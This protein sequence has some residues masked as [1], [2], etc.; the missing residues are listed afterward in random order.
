L[1]TLSKDELGGLWVIFSFSTEAGAEPSRGKG[2]GGNSGGD[3]SQAAGA[4]YGDLYVLERDGAGIPVNREITYTDPTTGLSVT[5]SCVQPISKPSCT[6]GTTTLSDCSLLPLNAEKADFDPELEDP[7]GVQAEYAVCLQEITFGRES[8][9]RASASVIDMSYGEAIKR[10]NS[11]AANQCSCDYET[12]YCDDE[13]GVDTRAIKRNPAG[14]IELCIPSEDGSGYNWGT[15]DAPLQNLGLY[16]E[17]MTNGCLG[18]VTQEATGEEGV[19]VTVTTAL[20]PT[21]IY[22][23]NASG[24]EHLTCDY[25]TAVPQSEADAVAE[26]QDCQVGSTDTPCW[27][28][29]PITPSAVTGEDMLS[30]AAFVAAGTDKTSP[31]TID[32]IINVNTYLGINTWTFTKNRNTQ[33]LDVTYFPFKTGD[34]WFTYTRGDALTSDT[35][36]YLLAAGS[37]TSFT[38][39]YISLFSDADNG[40]KLENITVCRDGAPMINPEDSVCD[41]A[42]DY[43]YTSNPPNG[44]GGANWFAQAAEDSRKVIWYMHNWAV[45]EIGY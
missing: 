22:Y 13:A 12:A 10:I 21:G 20:D 6:V 44:C 27:W 19:S 31:L 29:S 43:P 8:V 32:E 11:A 35:Q 37:P 15:M 7:C 24:F 39:Q 38:A 36:A 45:P 26:E 14:L 17:V 3:T 34:N 18:T 2:N 33:V 28:E 16:R 1:S 5:V 4:L 42:N 40:V 41:D 23:L 30:S 9:S 25:D